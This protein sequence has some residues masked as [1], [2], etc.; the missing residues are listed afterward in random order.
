MKSDW[1]ELNVSVLEW[2]AAKGI[3]RGS[4]AMTQLSKTI[5]EC[6]EVMR[7]LDN[8]DPDFDAIKSEYGDVLVTLIIGMELA[9]MDSTSALRAAYAKISRRTGQMQGGVFVKDQQEQ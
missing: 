5:E 6:A 3:L 7:E 8:P 9:G 4:T 2:A 1:D